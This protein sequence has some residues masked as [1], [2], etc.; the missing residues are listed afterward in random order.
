[1]AKSAKKD[2]ELARLRRR[3]DQARSVLRVIRTWATFAYGDLPAGHA[4]VPEQVA[5]LC[6]QVLEKTGEKHGCDLR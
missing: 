6:D 3:L 5:A 2:R 4:L 1:M